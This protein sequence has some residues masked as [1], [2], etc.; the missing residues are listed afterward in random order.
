M[1]AAYLCSR[2]LFFSLSDC[3]SSPSGRKAALRLCIAMYS[4]PAY[5]K[6]AV[7]PY[8]MAAFLLLSRIMGSFLS[9]RDPGSDFAHLAV[10]DAFF[11]R[12]LFLVLFGLS[13]RGNRTGFFP[14]FLGQVL[15]HVGSHRILVLAK[16]RTP[17]VGCVLLL[18]F[19][20]VE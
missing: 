20:S 17:A 12:R 7:F 2:V 6:L 4:A 14:F 19:I 18:I 8:P 15:L 9:P 3:P 13:N 5:V 1:K 10:S 11:L 16:N